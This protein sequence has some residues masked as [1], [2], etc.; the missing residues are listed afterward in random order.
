[1]SQKE[2]FRP[3]PGALLNPKVDPVFKSLFT[4]NSKDSQAALTSFL[5]AMLGQKITDVTIGQNELPI[6]SERDK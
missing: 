5:A 3:Y 4:Q 6:E 1:M 2:S